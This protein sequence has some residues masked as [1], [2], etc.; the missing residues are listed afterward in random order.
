[1]QILEVIS[2]SVKD[3]DDENWEEKSV[4]STSN[5]SFDKDESIHSNMNECGGVLVKS[6]F[7]V[8]TKEE[9]FKILADGLIFYTTAFFVLLAIFSLTAMI[10]LVP[11]FIDPAWSTLQAD[12]DENGTK[13]FT[14]VGSER[15]GKWALYIMFNV[16]Y[17]IF[18]YRD[19]I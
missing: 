7:S 4:E 18:M 10:F 1:M 11:F 5:D 17:I 8:H 13:C 14:V 19:I 16:K 9:W 12:F 15:K 6:L 3:N 2:F